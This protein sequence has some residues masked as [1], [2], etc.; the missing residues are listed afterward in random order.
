MT[1]FWTRVAMIGLAGGAMTACA[2]PQYPTAEGQASRAPLT[3]PTANFPITQGGAQAV[4]TPPQ[5][6]ATA[7]PSGGTIQS[8]ALPPP[9]ATAPTATA[10]ASQPLAPLA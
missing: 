2:T 3:A 8:T 10:V 9:G 5:N 1:H 4:L 7:A 6:G